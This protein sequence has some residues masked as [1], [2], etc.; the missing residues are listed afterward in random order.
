MDLA[1]R[2]PAWTLNR[3]PLGEPVLDDVLRR[4]AHIFD[5]PVDAGAAADLLDELR[6]ELRGRVAQGRAPRPEPDAG[7]V[8][9]LG[10]LLADAPPSPAP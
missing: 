6:A 8:A 1:D 3:S 4:G 9:L 2:A 10:I 7:R 5:Q